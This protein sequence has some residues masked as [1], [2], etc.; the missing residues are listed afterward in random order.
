MENEDFTLDF[1]GYKAMCHCRPIIQRLH[2]MRDPKIV[3][4]EKHI[5]LSRQHETILDC[6]TL[7]KCYEQI[8]GEA[9][10]NYN[11]KQKRKDRR[12]ENYLKTILNDK[13]QG[14]H[15]NVKA[16]GSRKPAYE[17]IIQLGNRDNRPD[18]EESTKVL[19]DFCTYLIEKYPNI[20]PIGIYLHND[21]FSIDEETH[22]KI[23]SPVHIHFDYVYVA[24]LGKSLKTGMELQSSMSGA[25]AEMGF[26]TAKGKGTAQQQFEESVRHDLQDFAEERGITI[27]RTPGEKHSHKQKP[28]YQQMKENEKKE[29][30]LSKKEQQL[31]K[32][33]FDLDKNIES[34]NEKSEQ[35]EKDIQTNTEKSLDLFI[36]ESKLSKKEKEQHT[37]QS[38]LERKESDLQSRELMVE[39]KETNNKFQRK[40]NEKKEL[41]LA[42]REKVVELG[43]APLLKKQKE[44]DEQ[45]KEIDQKFKNADKT[46]QD[47]QTI[48]DE[49]KKAS[50]NLELEQNDLE[51]NKSLFKISTQKVVAYNQICDEVER[52]SMTIDSEIRAFK[53]NRFE[54]FTSRF[55]KFVGNVKKI[56]TAITTELN[57][58]KEVFKDFWNKTSKDF[59]HLA[60]VM[61]RNKCEKFSDY[62]KKFYNAEL[63]Y[64]IQ[65]MNQIQMQ[66]TIRQKKINDDYEWEI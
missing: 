50:K 23:Y 2:N 38:E 54:D 4:S 28:V 59:R 56:V 49:N 5:D 9:V 60:D 42:E 15:K 44:L 47:A 8:F 32:E 46:L 43:E 55:N 19:K 10:K 61:D 65:E 30:R 34:F 6:G 36:K 3:C 48:Q 58:Y 20:V 39:I 24:H 13:R 62:N 29:K 16:D 31:E 40:R 26:V 33:R 57:W 22:Q 53:I 51:R 21:E 64:Q 17:M 41:E 27:D 11:A 12:I 66:H 35:L 14:K 1:M 18:D 37:K 63:D 25:L 52:N 7:E 45:K